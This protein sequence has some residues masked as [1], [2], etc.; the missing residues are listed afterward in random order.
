MVAGTVARTR[1]NALDLTIERS[2]RGDS[3]F[4]EIRIW[5]RTRDYCRPPIDDFPEGS[6]WVMALYR[7]NEVP[8]GGF[9]PGTPNFSFGRK[10]DYYLSSCGG[11]WLNYS[12]EAVTGNLVDAPRWAREPD[13]Q[14]V[15]M[16]LLEAFVKGRADREAL[17]EATREDPALNDLMLDTRAF[18][19]GDDALDLDKPPRREP[20]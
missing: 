4:E 20:R 14:P 15:L 1:G 5:L 10:G 16:P 9:N 13:M 11:Y 19:R 18:L 12:G 3:W 8:E 2:L 7:I 6:R 17:A